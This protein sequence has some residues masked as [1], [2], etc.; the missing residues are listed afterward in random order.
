MANRDVTNR[1]YVLGLAAASLAL[2]F[3]MPQICVSVLFK[4]ISQELSL[5]P[6]EIGVVWG[7]VHLAGLFVLFVGGL[8]TDRYGAKRILVITC[9]LA[10]VGGALR[11]V[12]GDFFSLVASTFLF[13]FMVSIM[14]AGAV[15]A[16]AILFS[17]RQFGTANGI[18]AAG[19]GFGFTLGAMISATLLS[20]L[21]GGWRNVFF[22]YGAVS[23]IVSL[24]WLF[25][26]KEAG[27]SGASGSGSGLSL[28]QTVAQVLPVK[29]V[30]L[31]GLVLLGFV[32]CVQGMSGYL[33]LYLRESGWTAAGADGT[34]AA[35]AGVG[36]MAAIP[37]AVLSDRIGLRKA[38]II[39]GL[40]VII[41]GVALLPVANMADSAIVWIIMIAMGIFRD[42]SMTLC[43]T[44]TVEAE[45][46]GPIYSGTA[47]GLMHTISRVGA[48]ISPPLGNSMVIIS[49]ASPFLLWAAF[50]L[51]AVVSLSFVKETGRRKVRIR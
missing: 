29:S 19:M 31:M 15:K 46:V 51:L 47:I 36:A 50:G 4:E 37:I 27:Q 22:F 1:W 49:P 18:M 44:M 32:G 8:L 21:L 45:G 48:V 5:S 34:L 9:F 30:W 16:A 14:F 40:V 6:V 13:G 39:P 42:A 25:T 35:F 24:L 33:P 7:T 43:N 17:G 12:S 26:V 38:I 10:G 3:A 41:T 23:V 2:S 28:R 11:G 20:P